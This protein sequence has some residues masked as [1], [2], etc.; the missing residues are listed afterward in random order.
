VFSECSKSFC[1]PPGVTYVFPPFVHPCV[2][3]HVC[4]SMYYSLSVPQ[5]DFPCM[6]LS[7]SSRIP[8]CVFLLYVPQ[9]VPPC[10]SPY[11]FCV[12]P[13]M[14]LVVSAPLC[15]ERPSSSFF[16]R[17]RRRNV[18]FRCITVWYASHET[19][20]REHQKARSLIALAASGSTD[21]NFSCSTRL[22]CS[23]ITTPNFD[24]AFVT[25]LANRSHSSP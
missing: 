24:P 1:V 18:L 8:P 25:K 14:S 5:C 9:C 23:S 20:N 7:V 17:A 19:P 22:P 13:C 16:R 21:H 11:F 12:S 4:A 6:C 15:D 2:F 3:P 10:V